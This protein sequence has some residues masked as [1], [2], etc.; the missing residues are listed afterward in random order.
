MGVSE[1]TLS[2]WERGV[3]VPSAIKRVAAERF[4]V[5]LTRSTSNAA[6]EDIAES[7]RRTGLFRGPML[8]QAI[9]M[10]QRQY[11][12]DVEREDVPREA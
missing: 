2:N 1:R 8:Q 9:E 10:A 12:Q 3:L 6:L 5:R 4:L 7:V 11:L